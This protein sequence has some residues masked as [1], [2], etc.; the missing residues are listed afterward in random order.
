MNTPKAMF[1]RLEAMETLTTAGLSK[2][3]FDRSLTRALGEFVKEGG[4][5]R[6]IEGVEV[7]I[8]DGAIRFVFR[9]K[10]N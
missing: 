8:S 7:Q 5:V 2:R 6:L 3:E 4:N 10:P 9:I 1:V